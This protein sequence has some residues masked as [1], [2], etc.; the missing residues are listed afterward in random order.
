M[1]LGIIICIVWILSFGILLWSFPYFENCPKAWNYFP[2]VS[3]INK[4]KKIGFVISFVLFF[5][6]PPVFLILELIM[7]AIFSLSYK[8]RKPLLH[9]PRDVY[10]DDFKEKIDDRMGYHPD[11]KDKI[12]DRMGE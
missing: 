9:K 5:I 12:D 11:F 3:L 7:M 1:I 8:K 4:Y 2:F 10:W 6:L